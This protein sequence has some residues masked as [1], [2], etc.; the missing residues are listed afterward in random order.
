M[1]V[2]IGVVTVVLVLVGALVV[3]AR[4]GAKSD[5]ELDAIKEGEKAEER[6]A[7][8]VNRWTGRNLLRVLRRVSKRKQRITSSLRDGE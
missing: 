3:Y 4:G 2:V 8:M 1:W 5:V 7:E 6:E